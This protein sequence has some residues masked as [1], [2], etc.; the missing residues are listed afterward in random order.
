MTDAQKENKDVW[1]KPGRYVKYLKLG[2][3]GYRNI[4]RIIECNSNGACILHSG[5]EGEDGAEVYEANISEVVPVQFEP[6]KI[7]EALSLVGYRCVGDSLDFVIDDVSKN[8][9]GHVCVNSYRVDELLYL[10]C[11][12]LVLDNI[13]FPF[14]YPKELMFEKEKE[15]PLWKKI[16][17]YPITLVDTVIS[18]LFSYRKVFIPR[19]HAFGIK[20]V[21]LVTILRNL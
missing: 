11:A 9:F 20:A 17:L 10:D 7:C 14:G 12:F 8:I 16:L 4:F 6:F 19:C 5:M 18:S 15:T 1:F 3:S 21:K 2:N 13:A